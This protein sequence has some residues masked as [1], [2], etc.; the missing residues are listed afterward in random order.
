MDG[1]LLK[2]KR[3]KDMKKACGRFEKLAAVSEEVLENLTTSTAS[4]RRPAPMVETGDGKPSS[5]CM[6]AAEFLGYADRITA[7]LRGMEYIIQHLEI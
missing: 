1:E 6:L 5:E 3:E 2:V 4:I 7:A